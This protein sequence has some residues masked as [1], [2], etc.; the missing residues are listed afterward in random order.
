[1]NEKRAYLIHFLAPL[2]P[3]QNTGTQRFRDFEISFLRFY[4]GMPNGM[5]S[6]RQDKRAEDK[7]FKGLKPG[8]NT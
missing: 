7:N 8:A 1:M 4:Y 6:S 2:I 5:E 3:P